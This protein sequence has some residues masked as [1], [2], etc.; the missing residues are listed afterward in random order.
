MNEYRMRY[1]W[2]NLCMYGCH[3]VIRGHNVL[4]NKQETH[5][6]NVWQKHNLTRT[7][8]TVKLL[9]RTTSSSITESLPGGGAV[10]TNF[11]VHACTILRVIYTFTLQYRPNGRRAVFSSIFHYSEISERSIAEMHVFGLK[12][13]FGIHLVREQ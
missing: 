7:N 12:I 6:S 1:F 10:Y 13:Q 2:R 11:H 8:R 3:S 9:V 4:H 5:T